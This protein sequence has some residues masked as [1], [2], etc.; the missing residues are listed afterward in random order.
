MKMVN[1]L[2][3]L[4]FCK[5]RVT[6]TVADHA[7]PLLPCKFAGL[8]EGRRDESKFQIVFFGSRLRCC[9]AASLPLH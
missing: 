5:R 2:T 8:S 7:N 3:L 1:D 9:V 4:A 6:K